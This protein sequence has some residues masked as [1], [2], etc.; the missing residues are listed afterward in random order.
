MGTLGSPGLTVGGELGPGSVVHH[1]ARLLPLSPGHYTLL[2]S[3][4]LLFRG[5]VHSWRLP[6]V[7]VFI[8]L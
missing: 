1:T 7:T 4:S 2:A 3:V 8:V 5:K 6:Q